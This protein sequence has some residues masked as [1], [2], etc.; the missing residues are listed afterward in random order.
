LEDVLN[1]SNLLRTK[2]PVRKYRFIIV[3]FFSFIPW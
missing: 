3:I 1:V 2:K